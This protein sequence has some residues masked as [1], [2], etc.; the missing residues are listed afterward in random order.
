MTLDP[1]LA[2]VLVSLVGI[3]VPIT[4][5]VIKF[6]QDN[7]I[8]KDQSAR[9]NTAAAEVRNVAA[10]VE[11]ARMDLVANTN[12]ATLAMHDVAVKVEQARQDSEA[13]RAATALEVAAVAVKVEE[14]R[15]QQATRAK[16]TA[17]EVA[18]VATALDVDRK[19]WGAN[20]DRTD[21]KLDSIH[22]L[23]NSRLTQALETIEEL[24]KMLHSLAPSDK[25]VQ[26]LV[27][28]SGAP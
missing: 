4:T 19:A 7:R 12:A 14:A 22:T 6:V 8:A 10:R 15:E 26:D 20:Q 2:L 24:K 27:S 1:N 28:K 11:D 25:R 18:H 3:V 23:V 9:A 17:V 13:I 16:A 21:Q 5:L